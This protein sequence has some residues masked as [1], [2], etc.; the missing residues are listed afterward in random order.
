MLRIAPGFISCERAD[1]T[2]SVCLISVLR[3]VLLNTSLYAPDP[4][5]ELVAIAKW[6]VAE[7]N[8]A[9]VCGCL[10]TLRPLLTKVFGPL[11]DRVFPQQH[12]SLEGSTSER[13]RTVGSMPMNVFRFGRRSNGQTRTLPPQSEIRGTA[14]NGRNISVT[15]I[16]AGGSEYRRKDVDSDAELISGVDSMVESSAGMRAPPKVLARG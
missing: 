2:R 13:P 8:T 5:W 16:E 3:A 9:V 11:A 10:P 12:Q 1:N 14:I 6:S 7:T 15:D 4:T